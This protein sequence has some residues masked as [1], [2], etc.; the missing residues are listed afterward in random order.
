VFNVS[1][2]PAG[3]RRRPGWRRVDPA[4]STRPPPGRRPGLHP[5]STRYQ[6]AG[7]RAGAGPLPSVA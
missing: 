6:A 2:R 4:V 1:A 3:R 7:R 5:A